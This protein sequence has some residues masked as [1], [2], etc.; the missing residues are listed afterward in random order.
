MPNW[1]V[2]LKTMKNTD[3]LS[4]EDRRPINALKAATADPGT[5]AEKRSEYREELGSIADGYANSDCF[6]DEELGESPANLL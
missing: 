6:T 1:I 5:S 3:P 2:K 4:P